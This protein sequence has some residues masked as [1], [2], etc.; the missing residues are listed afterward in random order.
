MPWAIR[1]SSAKRIA[2]IRKQREDQQEEAAIAEALPLVVAA[3]AKAHAA[4]NP[5][6]SQDDIRDAIRRKKNVANAAIR[7]A[8]D[9]KQIQ[10]VSKEY[11]PGTQGDPRG[12]EGTRAD[13]IRL[14]PGR[15]QSDPEGPEG[16]RW[17]NRGDPRGPKGTQRDPIEG[18]TS[19]DR[20]PAP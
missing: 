20:G 14:G 7:R 8:L 4:G 13:P 1:A 6:T 15:E 9:L 3:V 19:G 12:P 2:E 5:L 17:K 11:R 16:T 18:A 10:Q